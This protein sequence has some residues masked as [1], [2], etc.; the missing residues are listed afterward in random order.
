V[1]EEGPAAAG[2]AISA[3]RAVRFDRSRRRSPGGNAPQALLWEGLY[4]W[5]RIACPNGHHLD[6]REMRF[7]ART[8][9]CP[10]CMSAVAMWIKVECPN[11]HVL[12]VKTKYCGHTGKCPQCAEPVKI[13]KLSEDEMVAMLLQPSAQEAAAAKAAAEAVRANHDD[14][15]VLSESPSEDGSLVTGGSTL[16]KRA[17]KTCPKCK[18]QCSPKY[19]ICPH[20]RTFLPFMNCPECGVK[21]FP[22]DHVCRNCGVVLA[23]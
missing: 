9:N 17:P 23:E 8:G 3:E 20:C 2:G 14:T 22:G 12:K 18:Q 21:S 16:L 19:T 11:K 6:Q 1:D 10:Q 4:V 7:A 13:P 15:H 5:I